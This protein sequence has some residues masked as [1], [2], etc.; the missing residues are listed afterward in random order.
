MSRWAQTG[1]HSLWRGAVGA[2]A[3]VAARGVGSLVL[4]K[5]LAV[6]GGPGGLTQLAQFQ[7]LLALLTALPAE[8]VQIGATTY[9]APLMPGQPRYRLWLGAALWV[10]LAAV[11]GGTALLC[12]R[13]GLSWPPGRALALGVGALVV[14]MQAL[15]GAVLLAAGRP[16]AYAGQAVVVALC[17]PAAVAGAFALRWPLPQVLL[18]YL[19]GQALA[20]PL[21]IALVQR[22]GLLQ[23]MLV[24][25]RPSRLAVRALGR[26][27]VTAAGTL[28]FGRAVDFTVRAY[29]M[30]H[31]APARTDEWQAV[32]RLSDLVALAVGAGLGA[33][34]F[35]R[36]AALA[37]VPDEQRRFLVASVGA[38]ALFLALGLG[39]LYL[40]RTAVLETLFAPRLA[41]AAS[42]LAPQLVGEWARMAGWALQY[43]LLAARRL[44]VYMAVQA[45]SAALYASLLA[46]WLPGHGLYGVV[47]AYAGRHTGVLALSLFVVSL[48][49][50]VRR[51]L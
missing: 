39:G 42:L 25:V 26:F 24:R 19:G 51:R 7:N 12:I 4:N 2:G 34:F 40:G 3:A 45:A 41:G 38:L 44:W 46:V 20:A 8:G 6:H 50:S 35:P 15:M 16:G 49:F 43:Q 10:T 21:V 5:L 47:L 22:A 32:A 13:G 37:S 1:L 48:Q 33:V 27:V 18:A 31:F 14:A 11:T 29:L 23:G 36:L 30:T 9:L 17:G 28:L